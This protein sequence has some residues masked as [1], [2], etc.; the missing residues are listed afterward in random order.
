[1]QKMARKQR[2]DT[3]PLW[4]DGIQKLMSLTFC[5]GIIYMT[6]SFLF[7]LGESGT[8]LKNN[9]SY[10]ALFCYYARPFSPGHEV[11]MEPFFYQS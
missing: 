1:M 5:V 11:I 9:H 3:F 10:S 6:L 8:Y 4:S 2:G 7:H